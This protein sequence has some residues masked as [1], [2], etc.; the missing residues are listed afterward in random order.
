[1]RKTARPTRLLPRQQQAVLPATKPGVV[2]C[3]HLS[4]GSRRLK[5]P[6]KQAG[7][8]ARGS[9]LP[10][11]SR[12]RCRSGCSRFAPHSQWRVR[13]GFA[14]DFPF[15][16]SPQRQ[17][18]ASTRLPLSLSTLDCILILSRSRPLVYPCVSCKTR[19][20]LDRSERLSRDPPVPVPGGCGGFPGLGNN[21]LLFSGGV[22][23]G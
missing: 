19:E 22:D 14:P 12:D 5:V 21:P 10:A 3:E 16:P 20:S 18:P 6:S 17:A 8:L 2:P 13:A 9:S 4:L 11:P 15:H 23:G 1:M 7:L